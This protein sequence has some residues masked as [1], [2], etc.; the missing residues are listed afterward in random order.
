MYKKSDIR[1]ALSLRQPL[2]GS[3]DDSKCASVAM[4]IRQDSR[5]LMMRRAEKKGDP[6]SG[7]MA[8]PGGRR[9][10]SDESLQRTAERETMEEVGIDLL[11]CGSLLGR[12]DDLEHPRL[13]VSAFVYAVGDV[14]I[15]PNEEVADTY[16]LSLYDIANLQNRTVIQREFR[17]RMLPWPAITIDSLII[18]GISLRFLDDLFQRLALS[19]DE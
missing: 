10:D 6:W 17:N 19:Q 2:L 14:E 5:L 18:W 1:R 11:S 9:E 15:T 4:M 3:L 8:F 7:H 13:T 16:W 12:L